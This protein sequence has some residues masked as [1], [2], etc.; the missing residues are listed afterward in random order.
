[1]VPIS[2]AQ[3]T[4]AGEAI[5]RMTEF[6]KRIKDGLKGSRRAIYTGDVKAIRGKKGRYWFDERHSWIFKPDAKEI[7][8][9]KYWTIWRVSKANLN[10]E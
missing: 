5:S 4:Y 7:D 8:A 6:E 9:R 3:K 1:M 2:A 10:D